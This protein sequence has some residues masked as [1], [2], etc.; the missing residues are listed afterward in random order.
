MPFYGMVAQQKGWTRFVEVGVY[1]GTSYVYLLKRLK[2]RGTPFEFYAVDLWDSEYTEFGLPVNEE[3]Y[4][5]FLKRLRS[6]GVEADAKIIRET[7][8]NAAFQFPRAS[9]DFVFIDANHDYKW[10]STD[11]AVWLPTIRPGGMI[12]GHDYGEDCGVKQAVDEHFEEVSV[13]GTCWYRSIK[14]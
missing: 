7:S 2:A 6:E 1:T 11:I 9:L 12:A 4:Q 8:I 13:M 5:H 3:H 14:A 10:V